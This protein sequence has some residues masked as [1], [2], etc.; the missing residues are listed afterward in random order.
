LSRNMGLPKP[1][2]TARTARSLA[3]AYISAYQAKDVAGYLSLFSKDADYVDYGVQ[4]H[5][6]IRQL[7]EELQHSFQREEFQLEVHSFF[8][9]EDGR[10]AAL[11]GSYTD[12]ERRGQDI[13]VPIVSIIEVHNGEIVKESLYYDGSDF[14]RRFLAA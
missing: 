3:T 5:K 4:V 12:T 2:A 1:Q 13:S 8:V 6:K 11:M 7:R 10:F 14:K 9:S